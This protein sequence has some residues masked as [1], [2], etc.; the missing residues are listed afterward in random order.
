MVRVAF[1]RPNNRVWFNGS[2]CSLGDARVSVLD[3]GFLFGDGVY[4]LV[5]VYSG[6]PFRLQ[7]HLQRL[8]RSL[9]ETYIR[10]PYD[11]AGWKQVINEVLAANADDDVSVYIQVT[12]GSTGYRDHAIPA[13][14]PEPTV[15]VYCAPLPVMPA[16]L[17]TH[18]VTAITARDIRWGRCDIKSIAL[19]GN[20]LLRQLATAAD[21]AET[22][23]HDGNNVTE[24]ASSNVF[25][26][27]DGEILTP[28][29]SHAL[30]P[31]TTRDLVLELASEHG[32]AARFGT[33]PLPKFANASEIWV[34]SSIREVLP[35]TRLDGRS[36]G[37]GKPGPLWRQVDALFQNYKQQLVGE[38][39]A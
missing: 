13:E 7:Q 26:V 8:Q 31:G 37:N 25:A 15:L 6:V 3:R 1:P 14:Q 30:L 32:M 36:V 38:Y 29:D 23:L 39:A 33:I 16:T 35:V 4:E 34:C 2:L 11:L 20:V 21:A 12:R 19:L 10:N 5:P 28:P 18:G 22:F 27:L 17:R 24:G 9:S